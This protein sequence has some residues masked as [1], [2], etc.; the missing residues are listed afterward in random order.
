MIANASE[1]VGHYERMY[2]LSRTY[3]SGDV[4]VCVARAHNSVFLV[5]LQCIVNS[6][7]VELIFY[8]KA[9]GGA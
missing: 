5:P 4:N 7:A 8:G 3:V 6:T 1:C 2:K 9:S